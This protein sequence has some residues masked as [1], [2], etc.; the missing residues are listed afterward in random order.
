[1]TGDIVIRQ[2]AA[3]LQIDRPQAAGYACTGN[4]NVSVGMRDVW[5]IVDRRFDGSFRR[6]NVA[7]CCVDAAPRIGNGRIVVVA[8][9]LLQ[10]VLRGLQFLHVSCQGGKIDGSATTGIGASLAARN[11]RSPGE[12]NIAASAIQRSTIVL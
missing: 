9:C 12:D 3:K 6:A 1:W 7:I 11:R 10:I 8:D 2:A 5:N 4:D